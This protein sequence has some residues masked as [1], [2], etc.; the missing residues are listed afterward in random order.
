[1]AKR[2]LFKSI[3]RLI[4]WQVQAFVNNGEL[5]VKPFI[6]PIKFYARKGLTGITGNI[7]AGLHEL[8][9]MTF[10]MH[11][12]DTGDIFIDVGANV[13]AYT[14]LASGKCHAKTIAI[15]PVGP[16]FELL[17]RNIALNNLQDH[18]LLINSAAGGESGELLFTSKEDTTNHVVSELD[19]VVE[20]TLTVPVVTIDSLVK[21]SPP[22]LMKIDVE[23]YETEVLN[24]MMETLSL[25]SLK[26]IIIEL[27]GSGER[28]GYDE[29]K[30]HELLLSKGFAAYT[31]NPFER[32]LS[33]LTT[34]GNENT[35][36]CRDL[37]FVIR[38]LAAAPGI[39]VMGELI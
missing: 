23:G 26:A 36:Y 38:R 15:E 28:Y 4:Y 18:V 11:F 32:Q 6:K 27:N 37:D 21:Y 24:G 9:D 34:H 16:T 31:Y 33:L 30:I 7:Y 3:I 29:D 35:I 2:H 12:L 25:S 1:M 5:I 19:H 17:S 20:D 13:G 22:A 8:N 39:E 14:L 10:L